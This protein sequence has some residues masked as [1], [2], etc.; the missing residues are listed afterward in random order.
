MR[1]LRAPN[2]GP[3]SGRRRIAV[4]ATPAPP[5]WRFP[6]RLHQ[7]PGPA[8]DFSP[9]RGEPG[10]GAAL[11]ATLVRLRCGLGLKG[12]LVW[13][14]DADCFEQSGPQSSVLVPGRGDR[15]GAASLLTRGNTQSYDWTGF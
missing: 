3:C 10:D 9:L 8:V 11:V 1:P 15:E 5:L 6:R 13:S 7:H 4:P 2:L 14:E 12:T